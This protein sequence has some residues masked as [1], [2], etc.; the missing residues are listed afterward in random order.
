MGSIHGQEVFKIP[1][2]APEQKDKRVIHAQWDMISSAINFAR[3]QGFSPYEYGKYAGNLLAAS[4]NTENGLAG[5][6][7]E[8]IYYWDTW[9][10]ND[11]SRIF[12][13]EETNTSLVL[14][15]PINGLKEYF[16]EKR[17]FGV[18]FDEM[19]QCMRGMEEQIAEYSGCSFELEVEEEWS[20][21]TS[22]SYP[23][24][25]INIVKVE[26]SDK[27]N[28]ISSTVEGKILR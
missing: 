13:I 18:S 14:K 17:N 21:C 6:G 27:L 5:F 15:I 8:V 22:A 2:S 25:V 20:P 7:Q 3:S 26:L 24:A 9:R 12:I 23:F 10:T 1:E 11:D 28:S 19:I 4:W 16:T